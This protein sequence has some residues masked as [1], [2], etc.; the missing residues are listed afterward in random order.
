M[1]LSISFPAHRSAFSSPRAARFN[2][3]KDF[4]PHEIDYFVCDSPRRERVLGASRPLINRTR[5]DMQSRSDLFCGEIFFGLRLF[6][7]RRRLL[8]VHH[9]D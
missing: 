9:F 8:P 7:Y 5:A 2:P 6:D 1:F 4:A 3:C